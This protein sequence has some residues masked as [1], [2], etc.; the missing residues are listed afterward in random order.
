MDWLGIDAKSYLYGLD[1]VK[2]ACNKINS[3]K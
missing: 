3:L 2:Q 1:H